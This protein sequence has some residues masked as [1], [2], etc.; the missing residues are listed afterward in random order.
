[1]G[2]SRAHGAK[3]SSNRKRK[4]EAETGQE[5]LKAPQGKAVKKEPEETPCVVQPPVLK[6]KKKSAKTK[7]KPLQENIISSSL[8]HEAVEGEGSSQWD[9]IRAK[10]AAASGLEKTESSLHQGSSAGLEGSS[11]SQP[12]SWR[13]GPAV[14]QQLSETKDGVGVLKSSGSVSGMAACLSGEPGGSG[15]SLGVTAMR[16]GMEKELDSSVPQQKGDDRDPKR[17][18]E[19]EKK[20]EQR[21]QREKGLLK[22]GGSK[23]DEFEEDLEGVME[24]IEDEDGADGD[25]NWGVGQ[26]RAK[27]ESSSCAQE[28]GNEKEKQE[29]GKAEKR[30]KVKIEG[31]EKTGKKIKKEKMLEEEQELERAN[32]ELRGGD[33]G[34][35]SEDGKGI[36]E[37][38][39]EQGDERWGQEEDEMGN[40]DGPEKGKK[41]KNKE[42][43]PKEKKEK[44]KKSK[45]KSENE[46]IPEKTRK[47]KSKEEGEEKNNKKAK[48]EE[49]EKEK[50][51]EAEKKWKWWEEE[52]T[53]DG[54]KWTQLEHRGPYF[55]PLYEPLPDD[56]Q[57]YYDGKPLKLSLATEEIATFYAKMLDHEYTTKEIFQNNFFNDWR[58]EMTPQEQKIIKHLDK[59]DFREI[60]KYFVDKN[61]ARKALP[62]EEKQK[63]K[64]AADKI[65]EEYGYC[66]LDGH[67]EKI[68][69]FKTEPPGLFRGRGDHPK[70]GMLKKRIMPEDVIINCSKDSKIPEP[71]AGHKW[72]EVRFDNTVTWLASWTENIQNS[73]KYIMLNPSSKLKGEKDW[74]KYEVARKLKDVVHKIRAQYQA[75]WKSKEMKKR[76]RAVALYFIDKLA[77]RAGNEKEEGETADT[78][79]CCSLRVEH[80]KLHPKLDGQ[81]HVVEFD[82]LG[83]DS[84]RYYNKVS[85]EK[86]VFKNLQLFMKNKDPGDDLFDRLTTVI[87]NKHLQN[88]MNGLTAKVFRTYNASITLQEQ[89]KA[90]TNSED[91]VAGKLLS[92]NRANRAVAILCN[93]QR[94]TPKTFEKS[95]QNLQSKID[96]KKQQLEEAEKELKKAEDEFEETKDAKA[97]ANIR[98]KKKLL[99]RLKEQLAKLNVQ[100]T[101]KE[102]NKQ[103]A[104]GTSKLNYLDPRI[105]IA[106]WPERPL[107]TLEMLEQSPKLWPSFLQITVC[108]V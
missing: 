98:K 86:P 15:L 89:L 102:E 23:K 12:K 106:C 50:K 71:P 95:M 27:Q 65:Q 103:I 30:K 33:V 22:K 37:E 96:A 92:Y 90:L 56:V 107:Q 32:K 73:L 42:K 67:R 21:K 72:K 8:K 16:V 34:K 41:Q 53:A 59:C 93:H 49:K 70:M 24:G 40:G 19:R 48:K 7:E 77:L 57:F 17:K 5:V 28:R 13:K 58:K 2:F 11:R 9:G 94:S 55:A 104:L 51:E 10:E 36:K 52:K 25:G 54:V 20:Q 18:K 91:S 105:S 3:D 29:K 38:V 1:M 79:G 69:N 85:V 66:I 44:G 68:G 80:I 82:F 99:E 84:I 35:G 97:E 60:H 78:V 76:Q 31:E 81:E 108:R 39:D 61:E 74:Q 64:E 88:L 63:L 101:D 87:L 6:G 47:R 45:E 43:K 4:N 46:E 100:A 75:D 26:D 62:K 83:K 14:G